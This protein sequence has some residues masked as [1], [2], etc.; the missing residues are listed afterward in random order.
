MLQTLH[1]QTQV[2]DQGVLHITIPPE[3]A[4]ATL[5]VFVVMQPINELLT[6]Q[7]KPLDSVKQS[8]ANEMDDATVEM[9]Q[10]LPWSEFIERTYGILSDD[11][12]E[13]GSQGEYETRE[14][15]D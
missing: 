15:I 8:N 3:F 11:P 7:A 13:R 5:D 6:E 4:N 10:K 1:F 12:I 9:I 2:D 14:P